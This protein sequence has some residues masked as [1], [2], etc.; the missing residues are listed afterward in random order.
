MSGMPGIDPHRLHEAHPT[1][2]IKAL[3]LA[4]QRVETLGAENHCL[5]QRPVVSEGQAGSSEKT[6]SSDPVVP[7]QNEN[8][9]LQQQNQKLRIE[10]RKL[11]QLIRDLRQQNGSCG[12]QTDPTSPSADSEIAAQLERE[13]QDL[14]QQLEASERENHRSA[15]P[16]S[17]GNRKEPPPQTRSQTGARK[18]SP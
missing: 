9:K 8:R 17:K 16:F 10:N 6:S 5:R 1:E 3:D 2:L 18:V 14:R 11:R 13:N 4:M 15:T 12:C 7:L